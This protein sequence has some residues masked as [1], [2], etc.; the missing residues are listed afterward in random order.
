RRPV[1]GR[2]RL[3]IGTRRLPIGARRLPM[4]RDGRDR[5]RGGLR[6]GR[7]GFVGGRDGSAQ[8]GGIAD[9]CRFRKK[10]RRKSSR[11]RNYLRETKEPQSRGAGS[12][13]LCR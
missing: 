5:R 13:Q 2:S 7:G 1:N 8:V 9:G 3:S 12:S 10:G 6:R 4:G 11:A